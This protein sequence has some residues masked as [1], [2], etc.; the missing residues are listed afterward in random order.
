MIEPYKIVRSKRKTISIKI[1]EQ[2]ELIINAPYFI[3]NKTIFQFITK[4][5]DWIISTKEKVK[6][7]ISKYR[8]KKF[9]DGENYLILGEV[10]KLKLMDPEHFSETIKLDF[11]NKNILLNSNCQSSAKTILIN[12]YKELAY[13]ILE[14]RVKR[15]LL[16]YK[17]I[18]N[19]ELTYTR[20]R[21]SDA[22][23]RLGSCSPHGI[24]SFSWRIIQ[25]PIDVV[26]SVVVHEIVHLKEKNH[27]KNFWL[28]VLA[29]K[30]TYKSNLKWIKENWFQLREFLND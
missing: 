4:H 26:D 17:S 10:H 29:M 1:N 13:E 15:Y 2:G 18:F 7:S 5:S 3:S 14:S 24:L 6:E 8:N 27:K 16:L 21:L 28:K 19:E 23:G 25:A 20:I 11:V 30:C 22:K 9:V 12:F